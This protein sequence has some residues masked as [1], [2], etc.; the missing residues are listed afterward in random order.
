MNLRRNPHA[1]LCIF[2]DGFFG[3]DIDHA[4][5]DRSG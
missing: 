4:G 2:N 1:T 5:P 3:V